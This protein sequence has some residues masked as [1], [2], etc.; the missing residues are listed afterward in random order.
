LS[1]AV[2]AGIPSLELD[3]KFQRC[4]IRAL[5]KALHHFVPV[6]LEDVWTS[7]T[8]FVAEPPVRFGANDYAARARLCARD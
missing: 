4:L 1:Q 7:A 6:L 8:W 5:L 3:E 2:S